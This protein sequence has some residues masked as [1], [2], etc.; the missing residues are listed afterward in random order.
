MIYNVSIA[1]VHQLLFV[2]KL[3]VASYDRKLT[4]ALCEVVEDFSLVSFT[5]LDIQVC[6]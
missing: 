4:K 2:V 5:P 1:K 6:T 3:S